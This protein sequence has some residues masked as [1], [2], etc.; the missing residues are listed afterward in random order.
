VMMNE[1]EGVL[2]SSI[3]GG[4]AVMERGKRGVR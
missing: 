4:M 2:V 1:H 3:G